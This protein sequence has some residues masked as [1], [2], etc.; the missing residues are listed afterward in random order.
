MKRWWREE[1]IGMAERPLWSSDQIEKGWAILSS[2]S[3]FS[4][5]YKLLEIERCR[6]YLGIPVIYQKEQRLAFRLF[7]GAVTTKISKCH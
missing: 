5:S 7:A 2:V 1:R 4:L 6:E 3:G